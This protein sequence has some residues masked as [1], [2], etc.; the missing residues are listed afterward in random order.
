MTSI[1]AVSSMDTSYRPPPPKPVG[2]QDPMTNVAKTLGMSSD[3]LRTQL[4]GGK[5]LND[6]AT[7]QGVDH[8]DLIDAIKQGMPTDSTSSVGAT[9]SVDATQIA[10]SIASTQGMGRGPQGPPPAHLLVA[11]PAAGRAHPRPRGNWRN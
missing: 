7:A 2:G 1:S 9:S 8:A 6:V 3:E 11:G 10:E 5:S 4:S